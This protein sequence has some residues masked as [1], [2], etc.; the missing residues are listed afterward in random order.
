VP[1]AA[2]E[3]GSTLAEVRVTADA[4]RT[5]TTEGTGSYAPRGPSTAATGLNLSLKDT[6]QSISVMTQQRLEDEN[7]TS[8]SQ[9]LA[10]TPGIST[11]VLGTERTAA[12]ARGYAI[13]NYQLDGVSTHSEFL[14]WTPCRHKASPT[15]RCTT[16]SKCCAAPRA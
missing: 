10:R 15:W 13:T 4:D 2:S 8:I 3:T 1:A 5:G 14:G 6:P 12:S 16:A 9:V 11:S 7:L